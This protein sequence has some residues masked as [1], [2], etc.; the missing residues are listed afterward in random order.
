[1]VKKHES[2]LMSIVKIILRIVLIVTT[3]SR[4]HRQECNFLTTRLITDGNMEALI[5]RDIA[6]AC[7]C[8]CGCVCVCVFQMRCSTNS[9]D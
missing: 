9:Q 3:E 2:V 5:L 6:R 4:A 1:M 7:V 8:V